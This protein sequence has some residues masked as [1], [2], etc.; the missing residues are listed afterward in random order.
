MAIS[1]SLLCKTVNLVD[2]ASL[3]LAA[4]IFHAFSHGMFKSLLFLGAGAIDIGAH[5]RHFANLG[6]LA[7]R[8]PMTMVCFVLGSAAICS[9]PPLNGFAGKWL[10]Y[11]SLFRI[12][13][14][15]TA[16]CTGVIA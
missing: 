15:H 6:G 8:M 1:I 13:Y 11:Q 5:S 12:T 2:V 10:L 4:A 3:A 14:Q 16:P 9:L 7:K